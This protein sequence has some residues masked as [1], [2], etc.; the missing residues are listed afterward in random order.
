MTINRGL[1]LEYMNR[2]G[3][4]EPVKLYAKSNMYIGMYI[5]LVREFIV[6]SVSKKSMTQEKLK[7]K[8]SDLT[9]NSHKFSKHEFCT[10]K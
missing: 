8:K 9:R 1:N 10:V 7:K 5:F 2:L 4:H 6:K 3:A